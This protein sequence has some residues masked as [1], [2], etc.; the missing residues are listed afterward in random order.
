MPETK[1]IIDGH[2]HIY[3]CYD[4]DKFFDTAIENLDNAY[5]SKYPGDR[6]FQR[7]LFLTESKDND[8]F[9]MF[10]DK[11]RFSDKSGYTFANTEDDCSLVL[12]K[13]NQPQCYLL[14]GRQIV[15]KEKLEVLS[16]ASTMK[17]E[18]GLPIEDVIKRIFDNNGIAVLAWGVGKWFFKRGKVIRT[19]IEKYHS[20]RL[21]IGDSG[22]RP[23]FWPKPQLYKIAERYN[24]KTLTGSDP[25]PFSDEQVR[26]GACG[27]IIDGSFK[28]NTPANSVHDI[29]LSIDEKVY[30]LGTKDNVFSFFKRQI[31]MFRS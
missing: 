6:N 4:L 19:I 3:D 22:S 15:T 26:I 21:F 30:D 2:V 1:L 9:T 28:I 18:D 16:I 11:G 17:I 25:F 5:S 10:K 23:S 24:M 27:S 31:K 29:L 14:A 20:S 13:N 12:L 8:Y 7:V